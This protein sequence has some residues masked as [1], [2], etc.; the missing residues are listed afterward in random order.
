MT[1]DIVGSVFVPF[2]VVRYADAFCTFGIDLSASYNDI[3]KKNN[4]T[5]GMLFGTISYEIIDVK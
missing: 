3:L 5:L 2:D 4:I 1:F